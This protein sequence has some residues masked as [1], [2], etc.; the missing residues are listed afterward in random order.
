VT[1]L[2]LARKIGMSAGY[3]WKIYN[4]YAKPSDRMIHKIYP[5]TR[6][7][8]AWWNTAKLSEIQRLFNAL[9]EG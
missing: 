9:M 1:Q 6:K 8:V 4:G 5:I 2:E 7:K 3:L